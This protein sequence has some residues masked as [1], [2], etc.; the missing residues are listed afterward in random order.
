MKQGGAVTTKTW[1]AASF[2]SAMQAA[3]S[4]QEALAE[5]AAF[6]QRRSNR[7]FSCDVAVGCVV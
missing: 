2:A 7:F 6:N 3:V 5:P 1:G 4:S